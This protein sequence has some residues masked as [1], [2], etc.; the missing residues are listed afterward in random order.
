[1]H[2]FNKVK[3]R[4]VICEK[5][6]EKKAPSSLVSRQISPKHK[7]AMMETEDGV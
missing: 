6:E 4:L 7:S 3:D 2:L 1:M 5:G